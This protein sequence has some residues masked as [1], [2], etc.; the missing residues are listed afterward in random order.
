MA[1]VMRGEAWTRRDVNCLVASKLLGNAFD[2][3]SRVHPG[4]CSP[5]FSSAA[6]P[7]RRGGFGGVAGP[8]NFP[9]SRC[10]NYLG[11]LKW[12]FAQWVDAMANQRQ[13]GTRPLLPNK[14]ANHDAV[15][16]H[17]IHGVMLALEITGH[18]NVASPNPRFD[19]LLSSK[20]ATC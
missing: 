7:I 4:P 17:G 16:R 20:M 15:S 9:T 8:S 6:V 11:K 1:F 14:T 10:Y 18:G 12:T 3:L 13:G 19:I 2:A 5:L